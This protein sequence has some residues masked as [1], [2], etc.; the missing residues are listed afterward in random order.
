MFHV[1]QNRVKMKIL[2]I[3]MKI[4]SEKCKKKKGDYSPFEK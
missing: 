3:F 1:K 2:K 4:F